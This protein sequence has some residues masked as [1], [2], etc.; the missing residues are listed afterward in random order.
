MRSSSDCREDNIS[1]GSAVDVRP[2][3]AS[4]PNSA[5]YGLR[6]IP[7]WLLTGSI[8]VLIC[9]LVPKEVTFYQ[10]FILPRCNESMLPSG[11]LEYFRQTEVVS[12]AS[13]MQ[14]IVERHV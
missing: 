8:A 10:Y 6:L 4:T 2:I 7:E 5:L 3:L 12:H 9:I 13:K 1:G 14:H 11:M